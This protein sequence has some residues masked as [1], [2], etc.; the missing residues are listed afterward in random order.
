VRTEIVKRVAVA[1]AL[2]A[3]AAAQAHHSFAMFDLT[4]EVVL[5]G[6]ITS[7]EWTNPHSW[8]E[9]DVLKD[10][11][12]VHWSIEAGSPNGLSR[13]GWKKN[14]LKA[15]DHVTLVAR[16]LRNGQPGGALMGITLAD[17]KHLG[18]PID[19]RPPSSR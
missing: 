3:V 11:K 13:Q 17:G 9:L 2:S 10:G 4:K 18:S 5:S 14:T 8:I 6:T 12:N 7:F 16:P 1:I 19:A 15:G